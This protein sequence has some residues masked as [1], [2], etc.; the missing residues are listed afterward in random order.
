MKLLVA[1]LLA[2]YVLALS[3]IPCQ[4]DAP[5]WPGSD[6]AATT[7]SKS[8]IGHREVI[9]LCSPFCICACCASVTISP[10]LAALPETPVTQLVP[11]ARFAYLQMHY[12]GNLAGIWQPPQERV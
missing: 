8:D 12:T 5:A 7:I 2:F 9:D 11:P 6:A 3:C 4:D 10:A 1:Y